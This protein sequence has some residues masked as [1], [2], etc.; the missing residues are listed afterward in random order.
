MKKLRVLALAFACISL[1]SCLQINEIVEIF[2]SGSG[3]LSVSI[4]MSEMMEM[5][6]AMGGEEYEKKKNEKIDSTILFKDMI[7][8][9][10]DL[11]EDEKKLVR[12]GKMQVK[13]NPENKEF[14]IKSFYS[15]AS[16]AALNEIKSKGLDAKIAFST[17]DKI[18]E[19]KP[20]EPG[21]AEEQKN[22]DLSQLM[23]VMEYSFEKGVIKRTVNKAKLQKL[24]EKPEMA[25]MQAG[26]DMG[27]SVSYNTTYQLPSPQKKIQSAASNVSSDGKTVTIKNNLLE[28]FAHPEKFEFTISY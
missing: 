23:G 13:L 26:A 25:D 21:K 24:K 27:M 12:D 8:S 22:P 18:M 1:T 20:A 7:A 9:H 15:F 5:M 17:T 4:D 19:D 2:D 11:T 14:F 6:Q 3:K 10:K 16:L 28:L